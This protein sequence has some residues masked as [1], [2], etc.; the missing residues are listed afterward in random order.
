VSFEQTIIVGNLG[1]DPEMRYTQDGTPVTSFSVA[2]S[3]KWTSASGEVKEKT[4]WYRC[5]AWKKQAE[6]AA[7]YLTKGQQVL[8]TGDV[9]V[10][11]YTDKEGNAKASLELKV[12]SFSF[13]GKKGENGQESLLAGDGSSSVAKSESAYDEDDLPF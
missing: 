2:V 9:D 3:R 11:A 5:S 6:I 7:Q 12:F 4:K 10:S 13:L 1:R 8:V